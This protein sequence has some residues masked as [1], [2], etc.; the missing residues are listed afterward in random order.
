[1]ATDRWG[2]Y[3]DKLCLIVRNAQSPDPVKYYNVLWHMHNTEFV[4]VMYLD[5]N[6]VQDALAFR[7]RFIPIDPGQPVGILEL[8]VSLAD[9]IE[10][11]TM[12]GTVNR[13][14]TAEWFW[15][16]FESL[17]LLDMTDDA[18]DE[19]YVDRILRRF[20]NRR[21]S[22]NG[23]GGLFVVSD[24]SLDLRE[25]EIW[26]QAALYLNEVL[27]SEGVLEP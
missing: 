16:M 23:K 1:M 5:R 25:Y 18:Y 11:E 17:G 20:V 9:R 13:N 8:M 24:R 10:T 21:Y 14:R 4:P 2:S 15:D 7:R 27:R 6:R 22:R 3:F 12:D 19:R 26:F